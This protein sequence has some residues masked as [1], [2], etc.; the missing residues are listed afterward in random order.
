V[1]TALELVSRPSGQTILPK[2]N[3]MLLICNNRASEE[4]L[5]AVVVGLPTGSK[6]MTEHDEHKPVALERPNSLEKQQNERP[7]ELFSERI[8]MDDN[9]PAV[10][11]IGTG[12]VP[13][14]EK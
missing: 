4:P 11:P 14:E 13:P 2:G 7:I 1:A 12:G 5:P 9:S 8:G 10:L 3:A 6:A